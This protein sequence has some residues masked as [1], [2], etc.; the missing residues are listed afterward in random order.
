MRRK[1]LP[2][3]FHLS[4][5]YIA[6]YLLFVFFGKL[7]FSPTR[8]F[9]YYLPFI[10]IVCGFGFQSIFERIPERIK[11]IQILI[12][13]FLLMY[14]IFSLYSFSSFA[15]KRQDL[16]SEDLLS[17]EIAK[18]NASFLLYDHHD[19]EPLLMERLK[20]FPIFQLSIPEAQCNGFSIYSPD[21][22]E[23]E[24]ITYSKRRPEWDLKD[25]YF[26]DFLSSLIG[27]C[28]MPH[29]R[30]N[31][32]SIRKVGNLMKVD[33]STE[34]DLSNKT[35]N[36]SNSYYLQLFSARLKE[37][38]NPT[39]ASLITG[40]DFRQQHLPQFLSYT[41]GITQSEG[42]GRWTD[43]NQGPII[44]GLREALPNSFVLKI[45]A[46]AFGPNGD[47]DT[48]IKIGDQSQWVRISS[49][50]SKLYEL[51]FNDVGPSS[52]I[53]IEPASPSSPSTSDPRKLGIGLIGIS[54]QRKTP[55]AN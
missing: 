33:S 11:S 49:G 21:N 17:S 46:T 22:K 31:V 24:F 34:I 51:S 44:I 55:D 14:C 1:S 13:V 10:L 6:V 40:I 43:S 3:L 26:S 15:S 30:D 29:T 32:A 4:F 36:G 18:T 7:T 52:T 16:L 50:E 53:L 2:F 19:I 47:K 8:H 39:T 27:N 41:S 54:F 25:K 48:L 5:A 37:G 20:S 9:L 42:W 45:N 38:S 12:S 35:K 23:I 28:F